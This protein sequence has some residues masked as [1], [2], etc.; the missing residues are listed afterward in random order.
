VTDL[1]YLASPQTCPSVSA[2]RTAAE[3][4]FDAYAQT[5]RDPFCTADSGTVLPERGFVGEN[6]KFLLI[7]LS[8]IP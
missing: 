8:R 7:P 6:Q 3:R 1:H 5:T 4:A 2:R